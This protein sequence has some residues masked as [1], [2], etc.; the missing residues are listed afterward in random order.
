MP[1]SKVHIDHHR[2][3]KASKRLHGALG[4]VISDVEVEHEPT[5]AAVRAQATQQACE[6]SN[7]LVRAELTVKV[8]QL[9]GQ[10]C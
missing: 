2:R 4:D 10:V 1:L 3:R 7:L 9:Q 6:V 5:Q 8:E